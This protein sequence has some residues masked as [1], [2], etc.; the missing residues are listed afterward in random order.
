MPTYI[1]YYS[2]YS[3]LTRA[4][5]TYTICIP[6]ILPI[7]M[8]MGIMFGLNRLHDLEIY[9][10]SPMKIN[11]AG[12]VSTMVF[13][14]T[15]TLTNEGL[16]AVA[17]KIKCNQN[18]EIHESTWTN[19]H[20]YLANATEPNVKYFECMAS[21]HSATMLEGRLLGD[22]L[23]IEMFKQTNWILDEDEDRNL[24]AEHEYIASVYPQQLQESIETNY[25]KDVFQ[26]RVLKRFEFSSELQR[27]SVI[28][29]NTLE[30]RHICYIKGSP[31]KIHELSCTESVP[32]EYFDVLEKYTNNGLRVIALGYKY[33]DGASYDQAM[34]LKRE[35][36]ETEIEFLGFLV[37]ANKL[38]SITKKCIKELNEG[39]HIF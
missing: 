13:D 25:K 35:E 18:M 11:T 8:I 27:M 30:D 33:L 17:H 5:G 16:N 20:R 22:P 23:E 38:K 34:N 1:K 12:R 2:V 39:K 15:G 21:C 14:K 36:I 37:F 4:A 3:I 19:N 29:K 6:A 26:L 24:K 32:D 28:V 10:T 7:V 31:E 9:C